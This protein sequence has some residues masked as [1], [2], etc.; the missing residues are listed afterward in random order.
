MKKMKKLIKIIFIFLFVSCGK[1]VSQNK[2]LD[3]I[4]NLLNKREYSSAISNL[5]ES[6]EEDP[7]NKKIIEKLASAYAGA[8]GFESLNFL[9]FFSKIKINEGKGNQTTS[10]LKNYNEGMDN[11]LKEFNDIDEKKY[12][13]LNKSI[14]L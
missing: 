4:N 12:I 6:L 3:K 1:E 10:Q 13:S 14:Q 5:E 8:A 9:K 7:N 2:E 11:F